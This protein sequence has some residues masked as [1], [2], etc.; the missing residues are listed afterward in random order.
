MS[1]EIFQFVDFCVSVGMMGWAWER[2]L[3]PLSVTLML[4]AWDL[5]SMLHF[6]RVHSITTFYKCILDYYIL[7]VFTR[8][9]HFPRVHSITTFYTCSLDYYI[10]HVYIRLLHFTCSL[11]YYIFHVYTRLL[12]FTRGHSITTFYT[13]TLDYYILHVVTRLLHFTRVHSITTFYTGSLDYY[14]FNSSN[15]QGSVWFIILLI[16]LFLLYS[17]DI[18]SIFLVC[19]CVKILMNLFCIMFDLYDC[20]VM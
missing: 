7:H 16:S 2:D 15:H 9:L 1:T 19:Y 8:L 13:C 5:T 14:I 17:Y 18:W 10:L 12:H 6:T 3:M 20:N 11:D 4:K